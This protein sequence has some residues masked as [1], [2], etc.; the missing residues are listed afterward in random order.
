MESL[1]FSSEVRVNILRVWKAI[2]GTGSGRKY[3][4]F[5]W[6]SLAVGTGS[7]QADVVNL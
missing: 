3:V 5:E 2:F 6:R 4:L 7:V 1:D